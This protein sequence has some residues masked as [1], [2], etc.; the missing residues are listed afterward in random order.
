MLAFGV[1]SSSFRRIVP[2]VAVYLISCPPILRVCFVGTLFSSGTGGF[3]SSLG[4]SA[5]FSPVFSAGAGDC[6]CCAKE[7]FAPRRKAAKLKNRCEV[8]I[9]EKAPQSNGH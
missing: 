2:A 5:A 1:P 4:F 7:R 3:F 8:F 9:G 6:G